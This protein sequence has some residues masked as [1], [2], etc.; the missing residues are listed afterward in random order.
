MTIASTAAFVTAPGTSDYSASKAGVMAL[1][2]CV[3]AELKG[4]LKAPKIRTTM[5]CPVKVDTPLGS[6]VKGSRAYASANGA[7]PRTDLKDKFVTPTQQPWQIAERIVLAL[8]SGLSGGTVFAPSYL[9][10]AQFLSS[11]R[12]S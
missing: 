6:I 10:C 4:R 5:I 1:H 7:D 9:W 8:D 12:S 11:F 2:E 3:T